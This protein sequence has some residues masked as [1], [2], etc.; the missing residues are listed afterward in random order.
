MQGASLHSSLFDSVVSS[1]D[2]LAPRFYTV[3][4][5]LLS[6]FMVMVACRS[7]GETDFSPTGATAKIPQLVI[8][9]MD[10]ASATSNIIAGAVTA[11]AADV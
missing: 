10:P 2:P 7:K 1:L 8:G 11:G 3:I 5:V 9:S 4:A 6:Y